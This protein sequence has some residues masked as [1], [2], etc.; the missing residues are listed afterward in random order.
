MD[1][2]YIA[3]ISLP[4]IAIVFVKGYTIGTRRMKKYVNKRINDIFTDEYGVGDVPET[5]SI[6]QE[7]EIIE[8]LLDILTEIRENG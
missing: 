2:Y 4:I 6:A 1:K 8:K 5:I 7:S 3:M